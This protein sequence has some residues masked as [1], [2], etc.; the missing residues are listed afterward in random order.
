M[1]KYILMFGLTLVMGLFIA[2]NVTAQGNWEDNPANPATW[3]TGNVGIGISTPDAPLHVHRTATGLSALQRMVRTGTPAAGIT[4]DK[5]NTGETPAG[6]NDYMGSFIGRL[7][8]GSNYIA[9]AGIR[10]QAGGSNTT[11]QIIFQTHDGL[12]GGLG[13]K[14][15][16]I[17]DNAGKV[18][19][20]FTDTG[21]LGDALLGVNGKLL[22][23]E[24]EVK[25]YADWPDF[26]FKSNYN[27]MP[28]NELESFV[29]TNKHLP[30]IPSQA[31]VEA[32]G[33]FNLGETSVMLLQKV[34]ELTL[35]IIELN[36][37]IEELEK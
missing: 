15:R 5:A 10:F 19:I 24:I 11:G 7:Y 31:S 28:L 4:F 14:T 12:A 20:G 16:M 36:K 1:K 27:L 2:N 8:D 26:V 32:Q 17:I 6:G 35:Y 9:R 3:T 25:L 21:K 33:T 30:G 13:A 29:S 22:A 34:E 18:G 23:E 37:R